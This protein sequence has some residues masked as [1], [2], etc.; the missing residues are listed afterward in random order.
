MRGERE[1]LAKWALLAVPRGV[2]LTM[3]ALGSHQ[4]LYIESGTGGKTYTG[5]HLEIPDTSSMT[6]GKW[7]DSMPTEIGSD[8]GSSKTRLLT[9]ANRKL[10]CHRNS[11][12]C[13]QKRKL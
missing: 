2:A 4:G 3:Q 5:M 1:K 13:P 6:R 10:Y 9:L 11:W 8:V 7:K 12:P